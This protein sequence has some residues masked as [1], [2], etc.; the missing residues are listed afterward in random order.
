M[1]PKPT[2]L[3]KATLADSTLSNVAIPHRLHVAPV[4]FEVD[5]VVEPIIRMEG[6]KAILLAQLSDRDQGRRFLDQVVARLKKKGIESQVIRRDIYDLYSCSRELVEVFRS[7]RA[8]KVF[9]NTSSGSKVQSIACVLSAMMVQ[10]EGI[11]VSLYYAIPDEYTS[12]LPRPIS[13]GCKEVIPLPRLSLQVP[14]P[15]II[16]AMTILRTGPRSKADLAIELAKGGV[17][18]RSRLSSEGR[19]ADEAAR[20]SL[21]TAVDVRVVRKLEESRYATVKRKGR[22][23]LVSLTPLGQSTAELFSSP[24]QG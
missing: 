16:A 11:D 1:W 19:P 3:T 7:H 17:L 4:G 5:R 8:D 14:P 24:K 22:V 13:R 18:D 12:T 21:Q 15:E 6:E 9:V 23:T 20:V 10:S 2:V